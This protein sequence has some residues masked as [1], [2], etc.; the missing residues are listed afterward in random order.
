M[1]YAALAVAIL[2][3]QF[4]VASSDNMKLSLCPVPALFS[5][6]TANASASAEK[7]KSFADALKGQIENTTVRQVNYVSAGTN[8]S[9]PATHPTCAP[10]QAAIEFDFCR[11]QLTTATSSDSSVDLETWLPSDYSGRFLSTGNGGLGGCISYDDMAYTAHRGFA[12]VGTNNGHDGNY[13]EPFYKKPGVIE[14]FAYRAVHT[15]VLIGK[16]VAQS[17]YGKKHKKSY[18]LSCSTGGRQGFLEA[19][20]F[21]E[22]FDGIVAGAPAIDFT[23]LQASS[24]SYYGI[25]GTPDSDTFVTSQQWAL[26]VNDT[27]RQCD[28]LDGHIDTVLEDPN[29]CHYRPEALICHDGKTTDCLTPTQVETVRRILS[30]LYDK[31]GKLVYPGMQPGVDS[32]GILWNGQPF[33]YAADWW[34]YVIYNDPSYDGNVTLDDIDAAIEANTYGIDA[35]DGDLSAVRDRGAKILHYHGL[36]DPLIT[37]DNSERYYNRV[38]RTMSA[39]SEELDEFY[40]YFRISGMGHCGGGTGA[41]NI[42]NSAGTFSKEDP[43]DNVLSAIVRW[44]EKDIAPEHVR[45]TAYTDQSKKTVKFQRN[46]CRYPLRNRYNGSGDANKAENWQCV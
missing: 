28:G 12:A 3:T 33:L 2:P 30:P 10:F 18:W 5:L 1:Q 25:T 38:A 43:E 15:G 39:S 29:L 20:R 41:F 24:G 11:V 40:R 23:G 36:Q 45:G 44:V 8:L 35:F 26:V 16:Q 22:D 19:Q 42:G 7:C 4:V 17:F 6:V 32:S 13:G 27:L 21:P 37:S 14:D 34:K 46:H 9:I 31:R